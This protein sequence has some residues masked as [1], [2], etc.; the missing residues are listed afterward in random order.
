MPRKGLQELWAKL[1]KLAQL[2]GKYKYREK[3]NLFYSAQLK[4]FS[5]KRKELKRKAESESSS[6]DEEVEKTE[7]CRDME[8][9]KKSMGVSGSKVFIVK[10]NYKDFRNALIE[11]GW[12]E[13]TDKSSLFYDLKWT[14]KVKDI[15]F[16]TVKAAQL[17]NH[18]NNNACLTS[19]YGLCK[20]LRSI[21]VA[22]SLDIDRFFPKAYDMSDLQD[23]E[24]FLEV[25]KWIHCESILK[26]AVQA[27][28]EPTPE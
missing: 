14:T 27:A 26:L 21:M 17:V 6:S 8:T 4:S 12:V 19:K 18:F 7:K 20:S 11:R 5:Y 9:W 25:Y 23:F 3:F 28:Q 13:N 22:E 24:N 10:G 15:K 2:K 1:T 16:E